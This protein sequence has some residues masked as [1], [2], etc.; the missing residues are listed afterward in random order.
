[1]KYSKTFFC[2]RAA[3]AALCLFVGSLAVSASAFAQ[4]NSP[5]NVS[6]VVTDQTGQPMAGVTVM[7]KGTNTVA[8]SDNDGSYAI[9]VTS[10][11]TL[12]FSFIGFVTQ[13][14]PVGSN[15]QINVTLQEETA[16][17]DEVVVVG[18]GVQRKSDVTGA[19]SSVKTEDFENR[20]SETIGHAISGKTAGVQILLTS[21][22]PGSSTSIRVRGYSSN[23]S[24]DPLY[25]VDGLKVSDIDYLDPENVQSIEILKD[26][27]SAAI[28]GAEAG[29]GVVLISTKA[30]KKGEGR[31]FYNY[32]FTGSTVS[33]IPESMNAQQYVDYMTQ[34]T[35]FTKDKVNSFWDGKTDTDW[36]DISFEKGL[37]N[38]HTFGFQGGNDRGDLYVSFSMLNNDGI[39]KTDNDSQ[40]R[41]TSQVNASYKVKNWLTIGL[42]SSMNYSLTKSVS[43]NA[44][45]GS[46]INNTL[47]LDPLTPNTYS[48]NAIPSYI[49]SLIDAGQPLLTDDDGNYFGISQFMQIGNPLATMK[50]SRP[51]PSKSLRINGTFY[52][53]FTPIKGLTVTSRFGYRINQSQSST[54]YPTYYINGNLYRDTPYLSGRISAGT[55]YQW[56]NF[57]NYTHAFGKHTLTA[58]AGMSYQR[59]DSD[60]INASSYS[61]SSWDDNFLYLSNTTGSA[62]NTISGVPSE[63][64][65]ISYFGRLGW[66]YDNRYNVQVNFRADAFDSSKL[67]QKARWGYFPSISGSWNISNESFME[68]V[69]SS[70]KLTMLRLRAS[71]GINGNI[72]ALSNYQ[73]ATT[74]QTSGTN[75]YDF[76]TDGTTN[77]V[78]P[79]GSTS[80]YGATLALALANDDLKW[81]ESRQL[82]L[83]IDARFFNDKLSFTMD[84]YNKNTTG[85]LV[86]T[87][88]SLMTG[89]ANTYVNAG[90]V[91]NHGFEFQLDWK[92]RIGD[93]GYSVSANW[94]TLNNM[95]TVG[96]QADRIAGAVF[97]GLGE[98]TTYFEEGYPVWYIRTFKFSH[99]DAA[100]GE[101]YY[102]AADGS[103][104]T[105]PVDTDKTYTGDGVPDLTYG[106]TLSLNYK[107]FDFTIFGSG[108]QGVDR[109]YALTRGDYLEVN[110]AAFFY[111]D[112]WSSSNPNAKY[113]S[114][115]YQYTQSKYFLQSDLFVLDGSYFKIKQIQ[116]GYTLPA[117]LARKIKM[118][119]LRVY[120]SLED[121]FT[122]TQYP[123][124]DPETISG[125][126]TH[127][128]IDQGSYPNPK[129]MVFGVNVSF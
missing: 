88:P 86:R 70:K 118:S 91:H 110:R 65:A 29:N 66:N 47:I 128:A 27:A 42:T 11:S 75:G 20:S 82:D 2:G 49:Q 99:V 26:A 56:E 61:L 100:T 121:Y 3:F 76:G 93:F 46:V 19:I 117:N 63:S 34:S 7:V 113:P 53:N 55:F 78:Y 124:F 105:T 126:T 22:A 84:F 101:S 122:F 90:K 58:M 98:G 102:F 71:Y 111:T 17:L 60:Y 36:Q 89:A 79:T 16:L 21:G 80:G 97:Q 45:N 10:S 114:P 52:A 25:I 109:F 44:I 43:S 73:Y 5:K 119:R 103:T 115:Y 15:T 67:S 72:S 18:Y 123:G 125:S 129:K 28:Y 24:S 4:S 12:T 69:I 106:L 32:M 87:S 83:G 41:L 8:F 50:A 85:L 48:S 14:V 107:N 23:S 35:A 39:V 31:V 40:K 74:L 68:D 127:M 1:M 54:Y 94:A 9:Q 51:N 64:A 77:A 104:T 62:S 95:V 33:H 59:N 38:R 120:A 92:D 116:L 6:G 13:E 96:P 112:A 37:M 30:G 81:E 57:A 108:V